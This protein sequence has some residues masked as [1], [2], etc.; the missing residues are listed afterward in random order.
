MNKFYLILFAVL[1]IQAFSMELDESR[2]KHTIEK[3]KIQREKTLKSLS[4]NKKSKRDPSS[5]KTTFDEF[6]SFMNNS[7]DKEWLKEIDQL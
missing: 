1:S 3:S 5:I 2:V 7:N 6:E 4:K